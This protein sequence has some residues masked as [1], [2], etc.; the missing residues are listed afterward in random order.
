MRSRTTRTAATRREGD[1]DRVASGPG[2]GPDSPEGSTLGSESKGVR[3]AQHLDRDSD[4]DLGDFLG[5]T[6][7]AFQ[8]SEELP[9]DGSA[10]TL[11]KTAGPASF[12]RGTPGYWPK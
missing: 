1:P 2:G 11:A 12:L 6:P 9:R 8:A 3:L 10:G 5:E 4:L 7:R